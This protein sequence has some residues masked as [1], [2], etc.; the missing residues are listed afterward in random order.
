L[1]GK[2]DYVM[3][4]PPFNVDEIDA[5][6]V[7]SDARNVYRKVT[8][9]IC[10]F[11]PEQERNLLAIVRLHRGE[12]ARYLN[13]VADYCSRALEEGGGCFNAG[14][15]QS[16]SAAP[17]PNFIASLNELRAVMAPF[18]N[19]LR[20]PPGVQ[21]KLDDAMRAFDADVNAFRKTLSGQKRHG[22]NKKPPTAD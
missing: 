7:K 8:R 20:R 11:S 9:K 15:E 18:F 4:N 6:K 13:L 3:A 5:G 16:E 12:T 21:Q 17:V 22:R 14:D 1:L 2:A 19:A 10:D